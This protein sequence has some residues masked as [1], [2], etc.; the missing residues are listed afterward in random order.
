M[1][2][3]LE[4]VIIC[5][6]NKQLIA[7]VNSAKPQTNTGRPETEKLGPA[8]P[9]ALASLHKPKNKSDTTPINATPK[10]VIDA[11]IPVLG[12]PKFMLPPYKPTSCRIAHPKLALASCGEPV[13]TRGLKIAIP[14]AEPGQVAF[15]E[16]RSCAFHQ[17]YACERLSGN[18]LPPTMPS[19]S[20]SLNGNV[21]MICGGKGFQGSHINFTPNSNPTPSPAELAQYLVRSSS[22][23]HRLA[24]V[25]LGSVGIPPGPGNF[26]Q[27]NRS[28]PS[29]GFQSFASA[30]LSRLPVMPIN[31]LQ[32]CSSHGATS[33]IALLAQFLA[34]QLRTFVPQDSNAHPSADSAQE[35]KDFAPVKDVSPNICSGLQPPEKE[36]YV[37]LAGA[38]VE[39]VSPKLEGGN[40][41]L[42]VSESHDKDESSS[43]ANVNITA[44]PLSDAIDSEI[45]NGRSDLIFLV[46]RRS[47]TVGNS[48]ILCCSSSSV[49]ILTLKIFLNDDEGLLTLCYI[50][51][52]YCFK[53]LAYA[54]LDGFQPL[55]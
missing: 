37:E 25:G 20:S 44:A 35:N 12:P 27:C 6:G 53:V 2:A 34:S 38:G 5:M 31:N 50:P 30:L 32:Q 23:Q 36:D 26:A 52:L 16:D 19:R 8:S 18:Q 14:P 9:L 39:N 15:R 28:T 46:N 40:M 24:S 55:T 3:T 42:S 48:I 41:K 47:K 17:D 33:N 29:G 1:D 13:C 11:E 4:D 51:V 43:S 21:N 45:P 54:G 22:Q 10:I 7:V 49:P